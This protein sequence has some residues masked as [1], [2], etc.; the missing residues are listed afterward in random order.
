MTTPLIHGLPR[1]LSASDMLDALANDLSEI[2]REDKLMWSEVGH[3]LGRSE[4]QAAKY[5]DGSATMDWISYKRGEVTWGSRFTGSVDRLIEKSKQPVSCNQTQHRILAAAIA[6]EESR[7]DGHMTVEDI[8][9]NKTTLE[10]AR[11]AI[12]AQLQR[13]GPKD[14]K[15]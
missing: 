10:N 2:R 1:R 13:L 15:A 12:D 3:V 4:D 14:L 6:I 9:A 11:D 7:E 5:A 8:R